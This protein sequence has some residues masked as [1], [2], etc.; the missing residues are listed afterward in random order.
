MLQDDPVYA[1]YGWSHC[2]TL[3]QSALGIT[4]WLSSPATAAA[5][6]ATYVVAFRAAQG[7]REIDLGW[8][9]EPTTV[10]LPDALIGDPAVAASATFHATEEALADVIPEPRVAGGE[11]RRRA[12]REVHAR[13][14]RRGG[15]RP[16]GAA[17]VPRRRGL[18]R[19]VV[20]E[21]LTEEQL[22]AVLYGM[23]LPLLD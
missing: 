12:P 7:G 5:I 19:R 6:A 3:P 11:S 21:P 23:C 1:P 16:G 4:P 20:G 10:G 15:R 22:P 14:P 2:L 18:P 13:V 8:E 9:P 17:A